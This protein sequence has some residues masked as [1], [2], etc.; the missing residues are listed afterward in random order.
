MN[1]DMETFTFTFYSVNKLAD[2][3]HESDSHELS[4]VGCSIGKEAAHGQ[5]GSPGGAVIV[6]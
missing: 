4:H 5:S 1:R 3:M 2:S 6:W